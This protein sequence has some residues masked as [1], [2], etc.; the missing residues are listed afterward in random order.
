MSAPLPE[1]QHFQYAFTAHI[2]DPKA[3]PCPHGI[4]ARRMGIYKRL[5]YNNIESFLLTCFPV[6]RKVLGARRW[7]RLL[8]LFLATHHSRS[9]L[10]RE[11]PGE[12]IQFLQSNGPLSSDYPEFTLELAHYEWVELVL[13]ISTHAP[14]RNEIDPEGSLLEQRPVLNPVLANLCYRWPV[15]RVGPHVRIAPTETCLLVFRDAGDHVR[16]T[17]IN[18][19]TSRLINLLESTELTGQA[20]LETVAVESRH[21]S[22]E[23]VIQGGLAIMRDLQVRG[24]LLGTLRNDAGDTRIPPTDN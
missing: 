15:H 14:D 20:A 6:L 3:N 21:P 8:R 13:S 1:F 9:P 19:F 4:E 17:E 2:R 16:F 10:F 22:P 18:A 23:V 7:E 24:A 11:I 12:F 5:V